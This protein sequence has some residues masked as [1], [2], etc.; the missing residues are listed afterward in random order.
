MNI[1]KLEDGVLG[2]SPQQQGPGG[3]TILSAPAESSN[4]S[5]VSSTDLGSYENTSDFGLSFFT[6][7]TKKEEYEERPP[8]L[9]SADQLDSL[10]IYGDG[11]PDFPPPPNYPGPNQ[12]QV[13][14][15]SDSSCSPNSTVSLIYDQK[16]VTSPPAQPSYGTKLNY[17]KPGTSFS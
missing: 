9:Y 8:C 13:V 15:A 1:F 4:M 11:K 2:L 3:N 7:S 12:Q 17:V 6:T 5:P 16:P 14:S 10:P